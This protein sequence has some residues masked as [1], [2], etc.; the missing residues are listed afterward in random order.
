MRVHK[1]GVELMHLETN[2][3]V[4]SSE[5]VVASEAHDSVYIEWFT[6]N[7]IAMEGRSEDS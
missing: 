7:L 3:G 4:K 6:R 2:I 5:E 1:K